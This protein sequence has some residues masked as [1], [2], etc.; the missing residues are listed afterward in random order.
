MG[1]KAALSARG[2]LEEMGTY[3]RLFLYFDSL[4]SFKSW[5]T[6]IFP[7]LDVIPDFQTYYDVF[8]IFWTFAI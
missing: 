7:I 3:R 8:L 5:L 1:T 4:H 2:A 6:W